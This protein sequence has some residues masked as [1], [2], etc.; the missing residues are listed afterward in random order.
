M[1]R[2]R[3]PMDMEERQREYQTV[4]GS[5]APGLDHASSLSEQ[6]AVIEQGS[7]RPPGRARRVEEKRWVLR[8]KRRN[9]PP[10][11][12]GRVGVGGFQAPDFFDSR[13]VM[14][15]LEPRPQ[16]IDERLTPGVDQGHR[17]LAIG[18]DL[19]GLRCLEGWIHPYDGRPQQLQPK[20]ANDPGCRVVRKEGNVQPL[21]DA[22]L[23]KAPGRG[24]RGRPQLVVRERDVT[25][26]ERR[27]SSAPEQRLS[28][29]TAAKVIAGCL[30]F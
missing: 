19:L 18:Q 22:D 12:W 7:L 17:S 1:Q 2:D 4:F 13:D 8:L 23:P 25:R 27:E 16:R 10:P 3:E 15:R 24:T 21:R 30:V 29:V 6:V 26:D 14:Q 20:V 9:I 5:P 28:E 11:L